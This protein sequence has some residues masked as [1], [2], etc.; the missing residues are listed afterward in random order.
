MNTGPTLYGTLPGEQ[1]GGRRGG[2]AGLYCA[3]NT[4]MCSLT[5]KNKTQ[6][7]SLFLCVYR[8]PWY[9]S[10]SAEAKKKYHGNHLPGLATTKQGKSKSTGMPLVVGTEKNPRRGNLLNE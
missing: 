3:F 6:S 5:K 9:V 7:Y 8:V 10:G 2:Y 1:G 4:Q